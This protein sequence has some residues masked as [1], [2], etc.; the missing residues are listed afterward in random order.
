MTLCVFAIHASAAWAALRGSRSLILCLVRTPALHVSNQTIFLIAFIGVGLTVIGALKAADYA[1]LRRMRALRCP[2]CDE[3]FVVPS[4][5]G[6]KR[7]LEVGEDSSRP[8]ARHGFY[9]HCSRCDADYRFTES[10][11]LLT[12]ATTAS[13]DAM[14]EV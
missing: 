3:R 6:V 7:W 4:T 11:Q 8:Q 5:V 1:K 12:Q 14:P 10:G 13:S 9:L 2:A